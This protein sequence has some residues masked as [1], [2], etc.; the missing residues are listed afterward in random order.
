MRRV[1]SFKFRAPEPAIL[2]PRRSSFAS[3]PAKVPRICGRKD[4]RPQAMVAEA[5]FA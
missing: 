5:Q 2:I 1:R 3:T 4:L